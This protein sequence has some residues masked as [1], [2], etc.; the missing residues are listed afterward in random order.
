[1]TPALGAWVLGRGTTRLDLKTLGMTL[2]AWGVLPILGLV[3]ADIQTHRVD[4]AASGAW[5]WLTLFATMT[6]AGAALLAGTRMRESNQSCRT[7]CRQA[8]R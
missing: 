1:M 6:G 7:S 5:L 3:L 8:L 2:A 4:W